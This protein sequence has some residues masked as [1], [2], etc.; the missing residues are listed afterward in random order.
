MGIL[1]LL[2]AMLL[3]MPTEAAGPA[4][5]ILQAT[6]GFVKAEVFIYSQDEIEY[7]AGTVLKEAGNQDEKGMRL[8][9][10][11]ILNRAESD[12]NDF[13]D[14]II[15]VIKQPYQF[16]YQYGAPGRQD[17]YDAVYKELAER[18]DY[19]CLWFWNTGFPPY[20]V[21]MY[22]HGGHYFSGVIK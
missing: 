22:Q 7:I 3:S 8:V 12:L 17:I 11:T 20:G 14:T 1:V 16:H 18:T 2:C 4:D 13:P 5:T 15:E 19:N 10:A 6:D 9:A 21:Q